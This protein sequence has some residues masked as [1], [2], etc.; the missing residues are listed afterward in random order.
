MVD[1]PFTD[2]AVASNNIDYTRR[3]TNFVADFR[4]LERCNRGEFGGLHHNRIAHCQPGRN[5]PGQHEEREVPRENLPD[6]PDR[7]VIATLRP[8]QLRPPNWLVTI[9]S[10]PPPSNIT[11]FT[12]PF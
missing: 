4:E 8:H 5:F 1:D 12:Y 2:F 6:P 7:T 11:S 9:T 3:Q 10:H